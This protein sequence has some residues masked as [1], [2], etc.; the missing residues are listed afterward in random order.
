MV[1][2]KQLKPANA[3]KLTPVEDIAAAWGVTPKTITNWCEFIYQ[4]FGVMLP[5]NG[6]FPEWGVQLLTLCA[7][8]VSGKASMYFAETGERRRLRGSEF[9]QKVRKL[10]SEG[11]FQEFQQFQKG[12]NFQNFQNFQ[13]EELEDEVFAEVGAIV[14]GEDDEIEQI[15]SSIQAKENER[16]EE[17]ATFIE[18]APQRKMG[19]LLQRLQ[20]GKALQ[21]VRSDEPPSIGAAIDVTFKRLPG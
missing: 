9:V 15:R 20:A 5:S 6:P 14:R 16:V 17:L 7:K 18:A 21:A 1:N 10:K 13:P 8:H 12:G 4:G 2:T 19:K 11:H 3:E